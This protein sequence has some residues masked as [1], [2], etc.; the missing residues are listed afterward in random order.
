MPTCKKCSVEKDLELFEKSKR[1]ESGRGNVCKECSNARK[2]EQHKQPHI[3]AHKMAYNR[4]NAE[5]IKQYNE[6]YREKFKQELYEKRR[7]PEN[8]ARK[9]ENDRV[10]GQIFPEKICAKAAKRR[11]TKANATPIW[12]E[13][14]EIKEVYYLA[15]KIS[16]ETGVPQ[17]VDHIIPIHSKFVSGLHC[18]ANLRIIPASENLA[19]SNVHWPD[20]PD[21][22]DYKQ[23]CEDHANALKNMA[24]YQ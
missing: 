17:Q 18:M 8:I 6:E 7:L 14:D 5:R 20:M 23:L 11:A 19:K 16:E 15:K 12:A 22:L 4:E 1:T 9:K 10:Y 24:H 2:R 13:L 3:K 21:K